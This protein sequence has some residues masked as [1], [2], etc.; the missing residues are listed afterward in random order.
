MSAARSYWQ[1]LPAEE[2]ANTLT[3]IFPLLAALAIAW[4]LM[5]LA[6]GYPH[7]GTPQAGSTAMVVVGTLL[8]VIGMILM[9][10]SSTLY[11]WVVESNLKARLRVFDHVSIYVMIAGSYSPICLT[12]VKGWV[13]LSVFVFL[14]MCVIAGVVGKLLALGRHPKLSLALYLAMGWV[15]LLIIVPMW[16]NMSHAA[17]CWV[18]AEGIFYTVGAYFFHHDEQHAFYHAIWHVFIVLGATSHTIATWLVL[19][20]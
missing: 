9:F 5:Y 1:T 16:N 19:A 10:A 2:K 18:L 14:W 7:T 6:M 20:A 4:P 17:F 15:A 13:G 12:V 11:H 3:H 8:F